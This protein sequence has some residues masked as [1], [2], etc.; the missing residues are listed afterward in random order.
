MAN[1]GDDGVRGSTPLSHGPLMRRPSLVL[2]DMD[3]VLCAYSRPARAAYLSR[4]AGTTTEE[5]IQA[6]WQSGFE[7][8]GDT[9]TLD[10][11]SYLRGFGDRIGY[12]LTAAEWVKARQAGMTPRLEV[13]H[14]A[15]R[16]KERARI[17]VLTNNTSLVVE[18][19]EELFPELLPIF[20]H[21]LYASASLGATKPA[22]ECYHHCLAA[23]GVSP[24]EAIFVDDLQENVNGAEAAG[25]A[26][27]LY[28]SPARLSEWLRGHN[29]I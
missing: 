16:V 13:L 4:L 29:L 6:I 7:A 3:D 27:H 25:L 22:V 11:A 28:T 19:V 26:A 24:D 14:L 17:A 10:S 9:G 12:P 23:L 1:A 18:H 20:G 5:I 21:D 8:L 2:F 15:R